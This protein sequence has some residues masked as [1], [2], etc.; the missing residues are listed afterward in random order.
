MLDA[1]PYQLRPDAPV[2]RQPYTR[3]NFGVTAGGPVRIPGVYDGQRRTTFMVNY[4]GN[5]GDNLFDQYATVP[6]V[7]MR[8]GDF[9]ATG[10]T[11]VDPLTG[12]PFPGNV[13]PADRLD[14]TS[15]A[16][17]RFLP[18]LPYARKLVLDTELG[19]SGGYASAP[20]SDLRW[21]GK[22]GIAASP[23]RP[24]GIAELDGERVDVV[25]DGQYIE[26]GTPIEVVRVDG[27]RIVV[28]APRGGREES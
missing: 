10:V 15:L 5:R 27:N 14:P 16:L 18:Q 2:N 24:A 8:S 7:A 19:A 23:L 13:I 26:R 12:Q 4:G 28:R 9:S 6:S 11:I 1:E 3:Q 21:I 20:E 25:S 22:R 17:L